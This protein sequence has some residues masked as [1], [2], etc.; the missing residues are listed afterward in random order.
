MA[1]TEE[2]KRAQE[3]VETIVQPDSSDLTLVL[4]QPNAKIRLA[5]D[6]TLVITSRVPEE[7]A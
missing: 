6:V 1:R 2:E 5:S 4:A 3:T 7:R